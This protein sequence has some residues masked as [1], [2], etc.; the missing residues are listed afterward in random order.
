VSAIAA[1]RP[2]RAGVRIVEELSTV[3]DQ[4]WRAAAAVDIDPAEPILAGHYPGFPIFPGV[5]ILDSAHRAALDAA[6]ASGLALR[7]VESTRLL[8]GVYPGDVLRIELAWRQLDRDREW[9]CTVR[10]ATDRGPAATMR[11]RYR[12]VA[13]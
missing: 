8:A 4:R 7:T 13:A 12:Q 10:A 5:C 1:P 9:R 3:D 6:P 11:L 2:V